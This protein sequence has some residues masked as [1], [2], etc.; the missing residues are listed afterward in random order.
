M[1]IRKR[2][3]ICVFDQLSILIDVL[4]RKDFGV[5][6]LEVDDSFF[7]YHKKQV[8]ISSSFNV[9][10][11][12]PIKHTRVGLRLTAD[13]RDERISVVLISPLRLRE[14]WQEQKK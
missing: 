9:E 13:T 10:Q 12:T 7:K 2:D 11:H 8:L 14:S 3:H 1:K 6:F 5:V 4:Q